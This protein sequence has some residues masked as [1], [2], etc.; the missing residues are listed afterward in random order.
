MSITAEE[1]W[2]DVPDFEGLYKISNMGNVVGVKRGRIVSPAISKSG[3]LSIY[4]WDRGN[5]RKRAA[6]VHR[7]VM[8]VFV[9]KS[10]L[11]VDHINGIKTD[12]RLSNLQYL[13]YNDNQIK[14]AYEFPKIKGVSYIAD[15]RKWRVERSSEGRRVLL[16]YYNTKEEAEK[17]SMDWSIKKRN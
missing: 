8:E 6:R 15:R 9:G 17:V 10:D 16:G 1:I 11:S 14:Y 2:K 3:Y 7:L 5:K 4:L 13:S 12:N